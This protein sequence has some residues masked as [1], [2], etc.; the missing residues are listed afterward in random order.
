MAAQDFGANITAPYYCV[1]GSSGPECLTCDSYSGR[2]WYVMDNNHHCQ[3]CMDT[4]PLTIVGT[5]GGI[6]G[7]LAVCYFCY[8]AE[9][10]GEEFGLPLLQSVVL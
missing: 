2:P 9:E 5:V 6:C 10:L 4:L 7:L 8:S 3:Q 1:E